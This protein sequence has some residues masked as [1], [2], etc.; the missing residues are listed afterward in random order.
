MV[1]QIPAIMVTLILVMVDHLLHHLVGVNRLLHH[2]V[3]A[4]VPPHPPPAGDQ[5]LIPTDGTARP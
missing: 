2:L 5:Q 3:L 4:E 1:D